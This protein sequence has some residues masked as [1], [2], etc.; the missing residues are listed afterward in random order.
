[1]NTKAEH[2]TIE[3]PFLLSADLH[4]SKMAARAAGLA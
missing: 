3:L 1:M 4:V 2:I